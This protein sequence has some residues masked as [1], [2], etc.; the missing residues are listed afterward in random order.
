MLTFLD[1]RLCVIKQVHK[2]FMGG[3]D[4]KMTCDFYQIPSVQNSYIFKS[5]FNGFNILGTHLWQ[6]NIKCYELK[7]IICQN[8]LHFINIL[9]MF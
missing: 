5:K 4:V 1:C 3:F 9:N 7:Q 6:E 8:D 2:E